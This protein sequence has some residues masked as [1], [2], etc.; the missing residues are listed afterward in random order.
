MS[1]ALPLVLAAVIATGTAGAALLPDSSPAAAQVSA[2]SQTAITPVSPLDWTTTG[3]APG[4]AVAARKAAAVK[5]AAKA[6]AAAAAAEQAR[7]E[8][9]LAAERRASRSRMPAASYGSPQAIAQQQLAARGWSDQWSCLSS[10]WSKESGWSTY[11]ANRDCRCSAC[12]DRT[13]RAC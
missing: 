4:R 1:R 9:A 3:M 6:A 12:C 11:A 10:L 7:K 8:R 2:D 13:A 5:A